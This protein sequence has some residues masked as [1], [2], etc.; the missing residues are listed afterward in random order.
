VLGPVAA[1]DPLWPPNLIPHA[2][3]Q[4]RPLMMPANAGK[5]VD[6]ILQ[7]QPVEH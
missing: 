7:R 3:G 1:T 4:V 6:T 5:Q 2:Q